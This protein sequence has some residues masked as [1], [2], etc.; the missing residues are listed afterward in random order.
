M[1]HL[2]H[3]RR[4]FEFLRGDRP[5]FALGVDPYLLFE[6]G[7][8][9]DQWDKRVLLK[10]D[11]MGHQQN[12]NRHLSV[13]FVK[14]RVLE[15]R[16]PL[17]GVLEEKSDADLAE[18]DS[19]DDLA[20]RVAGHFISMIKNEADV[21]VKLYTER[22]KS[23]RRSCDFYKV[24]QF[25]E[26]FSWVEG[27][28]WLRD[29]TLLSYDVDAA[30]RCL[31]QP[32]RATII[33]PLQPQTDEV[34]M[35][36]PDGCDFTDH[37]DEVFF[38]LRRDHK[39]RVG[40]VLTESFVK[41][42]ME[43]CEFPVLEPRVGYVKGTMTYQVKRL[44][45]LIKREAKEAYE[46]EESGGEFNVHGPDDD[47]AEESDSDEVATYEVAHFRRLFGAEKRRRFLGDPEAEDADVTYAIWSFFTPEYEK[48]HK[49][50][51]AYYAEPYEEP[52]GSS[53]Q[54]ESAADHATRVTAAALLRQQFERLNK[55]ERGQL[56]R[57][58]EPPSAQPASSSSSSSSS[59]MNNNNNSSAKPASS[60]SSSSSSFMDNNNNSSPQPASSSSSSS[61]SFMDNNNNSSAK[62][63]SS[64]SSS[65]SSFMNNN[66]NNNKNNNSNNHHGMSMSRKRTC[67]NAGLD[68]STQAASS[69]RRGDD[70][71]ASTQ[72]DPQRQDTVREDSRTCGA[73]SQRDRSLRS[74]SRDRGRRTSRSRSRSNNNRRDLARC[75]NDNRSGDGDRGRRTSRRSS[76]R[77]R[78]SAHGG[79]DNRPGD[80][81]RRSSRSRS[82][83]SK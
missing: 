50:P 31:L 44:I 32:D 49:A 1:N 9:M 60:S 55:I 67:S 7:G 45:N 2:A 4:M 72:S 47:E 20:K 73:S 69:R 62:P 42:C 59:F 8:D 6:N 75:R 58:D 12:V 27:Y 5:R 17:Q 68:D 35:M 56:G 53:L 37:V 66:N 48:K 16:I 76:D 57:S 13:E 19:D 51:R 14:Q 78:D 70:H 29:P 54:P 10:F 36:L 61:S 3:N 25:R 63:A 23:Q 18:E 81:G 64:S 43:E 15:C 79:N 38:S 74:R 52:E 82:R 41:H 34:D 65:S 40:E 83:D 28:Q 22:S 71:A 80:R 33:D 24:I 11:A 21:A 46:E 39:N 30:L 77:R 26:V